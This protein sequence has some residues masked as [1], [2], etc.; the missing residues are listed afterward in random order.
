MADQSAAV[1][2]ADPVYSGSKHATAS[3]Q[4]AKYYSAECLFTDQ[5]SNPINIGRQQACC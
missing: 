1:L 5:A 4:F 3:S 2:L